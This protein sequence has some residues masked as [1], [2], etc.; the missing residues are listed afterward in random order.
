MFFV[1]KLLLDTIHNDTYGTPYI[2]TI[3]LFVLK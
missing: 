3:N 1:V 2:L